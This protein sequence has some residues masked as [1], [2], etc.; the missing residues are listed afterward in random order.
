M[1]SQLMG[2][3]KP[4]QPWDKICTLSCLTDVDD[5]SLQHKEVDLKKEIWL[6][7]LPNCVRV[8]LHNT[9]EKSMADLSTLADKNLMSQKAVHRSIVST[10]AQQ[11]QQHPEVNT[12][13][14]M[15]V[16]GVGKH[17]KRSQFHAIIESDGLCSYNKKF[18]SSA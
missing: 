17:T 18:G 8:L 16:W 15:P 11:Q 4:S 1:S 12:D 2:D 10:S 7:N 9:N 3:R 14:V 5:N 13:D 6:Q